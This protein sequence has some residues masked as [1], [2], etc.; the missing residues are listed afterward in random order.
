M[1]RALHPFAAIAALLAAC[2]VTDEG[3][4]V[5]GASAS[6]GLAP[7]ATFVTKEVRVLVS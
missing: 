1:H 5:D 7:F 6:L 4:D 2:A 3:V